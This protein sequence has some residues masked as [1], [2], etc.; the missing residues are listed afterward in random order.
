MDS[1]ELRDLSERM[2][3]DVALFQAEESCTGL[4]LSSKEDVESQ[5]LTQLL[6]AIVELLET[7]ANTHASPYAH[8]ISYT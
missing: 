8:T 4:R 7:A 1:R 2:K 3:E 6:P 5:L